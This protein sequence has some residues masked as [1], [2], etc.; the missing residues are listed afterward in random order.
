LT[1]K[2]KPRADPEIISLGP[3]V[4]SSSK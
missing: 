3:T 2:S 4:G 1:T